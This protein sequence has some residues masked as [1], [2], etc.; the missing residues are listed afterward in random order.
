[1]KAKPSDCMIVVESPT[2]IQTLKRYLGPG[3]QLEASKGHVKDLPKSRLGVDIEKDFEPEYVTIEGKGSVLKRLVE[4]A[5]KVKTVYLASDPDREGEAIAFHIAEELLKVLPPNALKRVLFYELTPKGIK[6]G[7]GRPMELNLDLYNAHKARRV[8]DRL[9]GYKISP[10]LWKKVKYGLSAGRVQSVALRLVIER[11]RQV[12]AFVP[13]AWWTLS[14][15]LNHE[16][17]VF[18]AELALY[19]GKKARFEDKKRAMAALDALKGAHLRV[20]EVQESER[21]RTPKPPFKTSTLQQTAASVLGFSPKET[22]LLAQRLYEGVE[23]PGFGHVGL[24]TYM[25]TDSLRLSAEMCQKAKTFIKERFGSSFAAKALRRYESKGRSQDAHEAI[26]PTE[27]SITPET[28][29]GKLDKRLFKLYRLIYWRFIASQM[30]EA[31]LKQTTVTLM[32]DL[33]QG[34]EAVFKAKG[35]AILHLGFLKALELSE[36]KEI[37][38]GLLPEGLKK[39]LSLKPEEIGLKEHT[40][41]PPARYTEAS[42]IKELEDRGIG[43]PST[44][45]TIVSTIQDRRYVQKEEGL[46]IPTPLGITVNDLLVAHFPKLL[47]TGFTAQLENDLDAIEASKMRW[48]RLISEFFTAFE[49]ELEQAGR[50]MPNIKAMRQETGV[51]CPECQAPTEVRFGKHGYFLSCSRYPDCTFSKPCILEA[52]GS[53][54]VAENGNETMTD[55]LCPLCQAPMVMKRGRYGAFMACS[56]YPEC[57][58][59]SPVTLGIP[60]PVEGCPGELLERRSKRGSVFFGCTNYPECKFVLSK[61]PM[62]SCCLKCGFQVMVKLKNRQGEIRALQCPNC[63]AL[64]ELTPS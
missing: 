55:R 39:G 33:P 26:R 22:M 18:D 13:K 10:L 24:I 5:A 57:K 43:R 12:R 64:L 34:N 58:G 48:N 25:R 17:V 60:C 29:E 32:A 51:P 37:L 11:E 35:E 31:R 56:R 3:Y 44:Y 49:Q 21:A 61:E 36:P 63:K 59:T 42:L 53:I 19:Q 41:K 54:T 30:S 8:L 9:V 20:E 15:K 62:P 16:G 40:S 46:L 45:A 6:E 50:E 7:M 4:A 52:D 14:A 2:K 47:D 38:E 23:V 28:L 27:V 1:M